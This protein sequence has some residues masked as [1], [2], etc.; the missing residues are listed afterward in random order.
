MEENYNCF[1][2]Q[3]TLKF[4]TLKK[5]IKQNTTISISPDAKEKINAGAGLIQVWTGFVYKGPAIVKNICR[6]I[7]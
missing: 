6:S 7:S 5:S 4:E 2:V 1:D 3:Q